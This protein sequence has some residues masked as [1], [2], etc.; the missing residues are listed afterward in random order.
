[1]HNRI[2]LSR[3]A[4]V[5]NLG[6]AKKLAGECCLVAPVVKGNAY[7]HGLVPVAKTLAEEG[8]HGLCVFSAEEGALLRTVG[9]KLPILVLGYVDHDQMELIAEHDL[10]MF[11]DSSELAQELNALGKRHGRQ[12]P[13]HLKFDTGM[14]RF[15]VFHE[16][17]ERFIAQLDAY[18]CLRI[19][20][21]AS[22]FATSDRVG[23]NEYCFEQFGR[24]Q[25]ILGLLE[26]KGIHP[27]IRHISNTAAV[28]RYP[29][30]RLDMIR[31]GRMI[32]GYLPREEDAQH[33]EEQGISLQQVIS[34]KTVVAITK[35]VPAGTPIGYGCTYTMTRDSQ[36]AT[37]PFGYADGLS[38]FLAN[39]GHVLIKGQ[40]A[41]IIGRVSMNAVTVDITDIQGVV[42]G[43]EV[44]LLG[45][46]GD[47][48]IS[49][50]EM[51]RMLMQTL[52]YNVLTAFQDSIPRILID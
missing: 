23:N 30:M 51:A 34:V 49:C 21:V 27:S 32:Y 43:D 38:R 9:I 29:E 15:G 28:L 37:M 20:G 12:I 36:I 44:V 41:P 10:R 31:P 19:E 24:F 40:R 18:P 46:Q 13:I 2:E 47:A 5:H 22:H 26:N 1:M 6:V 16:D 50:Y 8:A 39:Q 42:R 3:P 7:G 11:V 48:M 4:L 17:A 14:G 45:S 25:H 35:H 52:P 33:Y